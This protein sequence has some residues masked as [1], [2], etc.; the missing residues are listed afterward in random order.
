MSIR[1]DRVEEL[2]KRELSELIRR[3][4]PVGEAGLLN[5]NRVKISKDLQ[6]ATVFVGVLG[7]N[8]QKQ[9]ALVLLQ[10]HRRD[11][12]FQLG[13]ST[14]LRYTPVLRFVIDE[15]IERGNRVLEIMEQIDQSTSDPKQ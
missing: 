9:R 10:D 2:L 11:I 14:A 5:V 15:S 3:E 6:Q 4:I 7:D 1:T 12:Q 8:A 13:R